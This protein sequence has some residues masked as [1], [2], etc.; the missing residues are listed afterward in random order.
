MAWSMTSEETAGA[1]GAV[2]TVIAPFVLRFY[3]GE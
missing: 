3:S 1:L 2:D